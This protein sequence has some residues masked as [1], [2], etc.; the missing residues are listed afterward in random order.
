MLY[1]VLGAAPLMAERQVSS[2]C[3][4][5]DLRRPTAVLADFRSSANTAVGPSVGIR[6]QCGYH[7]PFSNMPKSAQL[8]GNQ[9]IGTP[10]PEEAKLKKL[11]AAS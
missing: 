1:F 3:S 6:Q 5:I 9:Q 10:T 8:L 2:D 11:V 4:P 7:L